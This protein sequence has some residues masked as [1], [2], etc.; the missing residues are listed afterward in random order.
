MGGLII[1]LAIVVPTLLFADLDKTYIR[2]ML[3]CTVWLGVIGFLDDY[4]KLKAR[5]KAL[6]AGKFY[7][8]KDR[9]GL[10]GITKKIGPGG[11]GIIIGTTLYFSNNV[12]VERE[13]IGSQTTKPILLPG[14]K[15]AKGSNIIIRN[16]N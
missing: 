8:K 5:K 10:A 1:L 3:L 16:I 12:V 14:E 9:D 15:R 2:L 7:S 4:F 6:A 11:L 13:I